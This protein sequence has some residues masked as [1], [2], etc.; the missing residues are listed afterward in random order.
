[1]FRLWLNE[2]GIPEDFRQRYQGAAVGE[3]A[4]NWPTAS[5]R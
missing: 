1:M 3:V 4:Q 5:Q 2:K